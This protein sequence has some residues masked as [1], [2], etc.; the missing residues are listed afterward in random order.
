[1]PNDTDPKAAAVQRAILQRMGP[2]GRFSLMADLS[3]EVISLAHQAIRR[4]HPELDD[5]G[6]LVRFVNHHY[7]PELAEGVRRRLAP[8]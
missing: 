2:A 4:A 6:I 8:R 7:G 1:M 5:A 3:D